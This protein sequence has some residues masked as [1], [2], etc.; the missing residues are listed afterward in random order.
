MTNEEL[1]AQAKAGDLSALGALWEQNRGLLTLMLR[2]LTANPGSYERMI[3]AGVTFED[4]MQ[5]SYFAIEKAAL[6]T[7]F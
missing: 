6:E 4:L 5:E 1:A 3:K 2:R 7:V